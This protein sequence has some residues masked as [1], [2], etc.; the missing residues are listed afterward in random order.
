MVRAPPLNIMALDPQARQ[1][2]NSA[3]IISVIA[4]L[5]LGGGAVAYFANRNA[6]EQQAA[7]N[8]SLVVDHHT[9]VVTKNV[10]VPVAVP[11][12]AQPIVKVTKQYIINK[13]VPP[14]ATYVKNNTV[15][16]RNT[17][18]EN[19]KVVPAP[20]EPSS[21]ARGAD[22][23]SPSVSTSTASP[24]TGTGPASGAATTDAATGNAADSTG[25]NAD[26]AANSADT[27]S[28]PTTPGNGY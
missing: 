3:L 20:H 13:P 14:S 1:N 27:N 22:S 4:V 8:P 5:V 9:D 19:T 24:A 18:I 12:A 17:T 23:A 28:A 16:T 26:N 10:P 11:V 6:S 7:S 25:S 2:S 15:T 21:S